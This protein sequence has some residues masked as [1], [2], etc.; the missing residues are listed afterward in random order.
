MGASK[1]DGAIRYAGRGLHISPEGEIVYV[2]ETV[3]RELKLLKNPE[4]AKRYL[5]QYSLL[6]RLG[7]EFKLLPQSIQERY[8]TAKTTLKSHK[9]DVSSKL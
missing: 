8:D 4:T 2:E 5:N 1:S 6:D 7:G 9:K 3:Q